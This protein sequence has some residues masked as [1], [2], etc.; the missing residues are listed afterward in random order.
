MTQR[1]KL[2]DKWVMLGYCKTLMVNLTQPAIL[3]WEGQRVP[4]DKTGQ[5][6]HLELVNYLQACKESPECLAKAGEER[7]QT[8]KREDERL[9]LK[10][11]CKQFLE[12]CY[13]PLL[14]IVR[15]NIMHERSQENDES[16]FLWAMKF[17]MEFTRHYSFRVDF[18]GETMSV[19][20][21]QY[22]L[23]IM[24]EYY[25]NSMKDKQNAVAWGR[26]LHLAVQAYKELLMYVLYMDTSKDENLREN[27]KVIKANVFYVVE[28]R[29]IFM[30]LLRKFNKS[31]QSKAYLRDL[32]ETFHVF[33][34]MLEQFCAGKSHVIV[35]QK[36]KAKK[37]RKH[38]K[39]KSIKL[40]AEQADEMWKNIASELS[41]VIQGH[42]GEIPNSAVPFDAASDVTIDQQREIWPDDSFGVPDIEVEDEF[43]CLHDIFKMIDLPQDNTPPPEEDPADNEEEIIPE[44][45]ELEAII[46]RETEFDFQG[47]LN[48]LASPTILQP[49]CWLLQFYQENTSKTNHYIVKMLHRI[50]VDL[51]MHPMLFQLSL[52]I[53]FNKILHDSAA[54]QFQELVKFSRYIVGKFF[55]LLP[56][57]PIICAELVAWKNP[58]VCYEIV[59]GYGSLAFRKAKTKKSHWSEEEQEQLRALYEEYKHSEDGIVEKILEHLTNTSRSRRQVVNQ[60]VK[61]GLVE[62]RKSLRKKRKPGEKKQRKK[63]SQQVQEF[64][65]EHEESGKSSE[66]DI[67]SGQS[68]SESDS[69]DDDSYLF[70]PMTSLVTKIKDKDNWQPL[71]L[72]TITEENEEALGDREFTQMLKKIGFVPP[73]SEQET[74]WRIPRNLKPEQL[75]K[76]ADDLDGTSTID[77]NDQPENGFTSPSANASKSNQRKNMLAALAASRKETNPSARKRKERQDRMKRK[78]SSSA[79]KGK[80]WRMNIGNDVDSSSDEDRDDNP[81]TSHRE[82]NDEIVSPTSQKTKRRVRAFS[83]SDEDET[84]NLANEISA[85]P[86]EGSVTDSTRT[87]ESALDDT[88]TKK[89]KFRSLVESDEDGNDSDKEQEELPSLESNKKRPREPQSD[90]DDVP[91]ASLKSVRHHGDRGD[92]ERET[93]EE[94]TDKNSV[95][96]VDDDDD[97]RSFSLTIVYKIT[98][99]TFDLVYYASS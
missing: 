92:A 84:A 7:S 41:S 11:F 16:Y 65:E 96:S 70:V 23:K 37:K 64:E 56:Q 19:S 58:D 20:N 22:V 5:H 54:R 39:R 91:L 17:F 47:F 68:S 8:E 98:I 63:N 28:Y 35:Q 99:V 18:V 85:E 57:N 71:P 49:Y 75:R 4:D 73:A 3:C 79:S 86:V 42:G 95:D 21:F 12:L 81:T 9:F 90:D 34:K 45:E 27:A 82:S 44:E 89:R 52:F 80:T 83:D 33:L 59:E 87:T 40:T 66:E 6:Y 30:M 62:D 51:K 67:D 25:E 88:S 77:T 31:K 14:Y 69:D 26:R 53:V 76:S 55:S 36:R 94:Q 50:A 60:L 13:N 32:V 74:F 46:T 2:E 24:M 48:K 61:T 72:V 10:E 29:D 38:V 15:D 93:T 1:V 97:D 78:E 43:M